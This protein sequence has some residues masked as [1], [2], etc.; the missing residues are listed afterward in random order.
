MLI[1]LIY[2]HTEAL[3]RRLA[4]PDSTLPHRDL[5]IR[6]V[7]TKPAFSLALSAFLQDSRPT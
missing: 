4:R 7:P 6:I 2:T 1:M 5:V 3:V